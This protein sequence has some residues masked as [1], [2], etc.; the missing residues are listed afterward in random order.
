ME[1]DLY[2]ILGV[3]KNATDDELRKAHRV[4]VRKYHPDVNKD[5]GAD[6]KFKEAQEAYD[7]LSDPE[8][9]KLYDQFGIAGVKSGPTGGGP[10]P[11]TGPK[12][13]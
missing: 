3:G 7:I 1:T 4:L 11:G 5:P 12:P 13:E 2:K 10:R 9:R 6:A 8:K